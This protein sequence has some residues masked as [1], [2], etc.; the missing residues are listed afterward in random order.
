[1]RTRL[2]VLTLA[3]TLLQ[4]VVATGAVHKLYVSPAGSDAND[5][6]ASRPLRSMQGAVARAIAL[7]GYASIDGFVVNLSAGNHTQYEALEIDAT[8]RKPIEFHGS[9]SDK[10]T[11]VSG[12]TSL[13]RSQV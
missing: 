11:T 13:P 3:M 2:I 12:G 6:T 8:L 10:R 9:D 4:S 1:M 5:G 7:Q